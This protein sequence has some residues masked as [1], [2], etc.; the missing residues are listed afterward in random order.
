MRNDVVNRYPLDI[1]FV[2]QNDPF[3][4]RHFFA[5]FFRAYRPEIARDLGVIIQKPL[6]RSKL[7]AFRYVLNIFGFLGT[8][9]LSALFVYLN[10]MGWAPESLFKDKPGNYTLRR[11]LTRAGTPVIQLGDINTKNSVELLNQLKPDFI[12]SMNA[13]QKF[14]KEVL[15]IAGVAC[16]NVHSGE[17]PRYR[18]MLTVFWMLYEGRDY[19]APTVHVMN[20]ELDAGPIVGSVKCRIEAK[21]TLYSATVKTKIAAARLLVAVLESYYAGNIKYESNDDTVAKRFPLPK[22]EAVEELTKKG[23]KLI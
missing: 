12:I 17:L 18:G 1:L 23:R 14:S 7:G 4:S 22:K 19:T 9:K 10:I 3:Y 6:G 20:E 11:I 2:T 15:D 21:D 13:S 8:L 16:L 5:E